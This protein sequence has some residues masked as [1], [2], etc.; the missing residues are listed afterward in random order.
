VLVGQSAAAGHGTHEA[1]AGTQPCRWWS[2]HGL[3]PGD[4]ARRDVQWPQAAVWLHAAWVSTRLRGSTSPVLYADAS[5]GTTNSGIRASFLRIRRN[6]A[7]GIMDKVIDLG[8]P[9]SPIVTDQYVG[10]LIVQTF[11]SG[12]AARPGL[13]ED[14]TKTVRTAHIHQFLAASNSTQASQHSRLVDRWTLASPLPLPAHAAGKRQGV[15]AACEHPARTPRV[16]EWSVLGGNLRSWAAS[17]ARAVSTPPRRTPGS[18]R[19]PA[20]PQLQ[21][22]RRRVHDASH[23]CQAACPAP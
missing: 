19:C 17:D 6:L 12:S 21:R 4:A 20:C 16:V 13:Q 2:P 9:A 15:A 18:T 22:Q 11:T 3:L 7:S 1:G 23:G 5:C 14:G 8:D 10:S